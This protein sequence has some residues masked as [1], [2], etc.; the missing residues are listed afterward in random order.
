MKRQKRVFS[1]KKQFYDSLRYI[2]ESRKYIYTSII[3]FIL[4]AIIGYLFHSRLSF[5]D[6][7]IKGILETA[8]N[9]RGLDLIVFIFRNNLKA[10]FYF[11]FLG[12]IFSII[13]LINSITNGLLIGYVAEKVIS[14]SS[15]IQLWRLLPHGIFELPAIFISAGLGIKLGVSLAHLTSKEGKKEIK[16][17]LKMSII[18]F[19]L[20][21]IPL[22]II[23]AIIEG[24]LIT[25][26]D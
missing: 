3:L 4:S 17:N 14:S 5:L 23:A 18:T 19:F 1:L 2:S 10:S 22:L 6:N 11:L 20:V 8:Q 13:P 26:L 15:I 12:I 25:F 16:E 21:I 7:L 9:L 24:L